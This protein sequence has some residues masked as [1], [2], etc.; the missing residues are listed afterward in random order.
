MVPEIDKEEQRRVSGVF[1]REYVES[2][3]KELSRAVQWLVNWC[4]VT[5]GQVAMD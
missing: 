1:A 4:N 3:N 2:R 5:R